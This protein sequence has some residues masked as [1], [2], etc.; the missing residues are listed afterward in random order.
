ML[1]WRCHAVLLVATGCGPGEVT[2]TAD[3]D[4]GA[5]L[6][7]IS[8]RDRGF[9]MDL[10]ASDRVSTPGDARAEL[11]LV[12][13]P[14]DVVAR[15]VTAA[16]LV[17]PRDV[18]PACVPT[19]TSC[20]ESLE[21]GAIPDGCPGGAFHCG[22]CGGG[23]TWCAIQPSRW[24]PRVNSCV[25]RAQAEHGEWF[26]P[27]QFR[28]TSSWLVIPAMANAYVAEVARCAHGGDAHAVVDGHAPGNEVR[29]RGVSDSVAE[30]FIVR[31]YGTGRTAGRYT[32]ACS[33]A[34]F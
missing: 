18:P 33:P 21:C 11:S 23:E 22:A 32:S 19:R 1:R 15:D 6:D 26:D 34:G 8:P 4:A 28:D 7:A 12:E 31:T 17:P 27:M 3:L 14:P 2:S 16:D 24:Q 20:N 25:Q 13:P 9:A 10:A 5:A 29:V 30:N